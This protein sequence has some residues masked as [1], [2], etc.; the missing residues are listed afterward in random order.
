[1]TVQMRTATAGDIPA[2][3]ALYEAVIVQMD[4]D[5]IDIGW[6]QGVYPTAAFLEQAAAARQLYLAVVDGQL[7]GALIL[8]RQANEGYQQVQWQVACAEQDV[9]VLHTLAT[10]PVFRGRGVGKAMLQ[11]VIQHCR[12]RGDAAIRLDV[13]A[14]N[15]PAIGLYQAVGFRQM[16][17]V[18]LRYGD[19]EGSFVLM[20]YGL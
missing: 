6:A 2:V 12:L 5:H 10:A 14:G 9:A 18:L 7:A 19:M 8:N 3:M 20:E 17:Q 1:M 13:V 15:L 11:F 4:Q 16:G